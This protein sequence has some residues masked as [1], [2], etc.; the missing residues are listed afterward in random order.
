MTMTA[1]VKTCRNRGGRPVGAFGVRRRRQERFAHLKEAYSAELGGHLTEPEKALVSQISGLQLRIEQMQ[2]AIVAGD[3]VDA[4]QVIRLS[5]EHRR[6]LTSLRR[7]AEQHK[8]A[9]PT[10]DD[11]ID[12]LD[13]EAVA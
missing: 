3:D 12:A 7:K 6:L 2:A 8:P 11:L 5:S 4:D 1:E 13:D 10:I 9:P